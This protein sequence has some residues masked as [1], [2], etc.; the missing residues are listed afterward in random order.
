METNYRENHSK[1]PQTTP[2]HPKPE[3]NNTPL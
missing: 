1:P 3:I 2:N